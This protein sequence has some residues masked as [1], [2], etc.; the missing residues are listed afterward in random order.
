MKEKEARDRT[1]A[2]LVDWMLDEHF[3]YK[4]T[5]FVSSGL[6]IIRGHCKRLGTA[7]V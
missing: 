6:D 3:G 1:A 5:I 2:C 4:I 7:I